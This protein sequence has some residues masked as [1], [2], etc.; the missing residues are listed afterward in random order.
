MKPNKTI[1]SKINS[2]GAIRYNKP[3]SK[4]FDKSCGCDEKITDN[5]K[6]NSCS[7][8]NDSITT[9]MQKKTWVIALNDYLFPPYVECEYVV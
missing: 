3:S 7:R 6:K 5:T 2:V 1:Y 9:Y 8:D 4:F